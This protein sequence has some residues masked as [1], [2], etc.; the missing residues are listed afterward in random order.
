MNKIS[1]AANFQMMEYRNSKRDEKPNLGYG[2]EVPPLL[3]H[4][5]I[6]FDQLGLLEK[7]A[8]EFFD[9]Y[10][11]KEWKT[12]TGVPIKNWKQILDQW[13]WERK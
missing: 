6:K 1:D 4:V 8:I 7:D 9:H 5:K 3:A 12:K 2:T 13:I 11:E 10:Q